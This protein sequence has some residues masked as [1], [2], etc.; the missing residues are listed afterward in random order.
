M[1]GMHACCQVCVRVL[2]L[3]V[4]MKIDAV[5]RTRNRDGQDQLVFSIFSLERKS[6][7]LSGLTVLRVDLVCMFP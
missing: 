6:S 2:L 3:C 5:V 4:A 1:P 7:R